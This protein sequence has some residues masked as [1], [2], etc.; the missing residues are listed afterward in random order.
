MPRTRDFRRAF[1][2]VSTGYRKSGRVSPC[3]IQRAPRS[4]ARTS[5]CCWSTTTMQ[6]SCVVE[7]AFALDRCVPEIH[8][9]KDGLEAMRFLRRQG[10]FADA[11]RPDL[12]LLDLNLRRKNGREVLVEIKRDPR[13]RGIPVVVL[14]ASNCEAD[15][16]DTYDLQANCYVTKPVDTEQ[17]TRVA[18]R[19][20]NS[21]APSRSYHRR[22][23]TRGNSRRSARRLDFARVL[24][25]P[26]PAPSSSK[27]CRSA[28]KLPLYS[29]VFEPRHSFTQNGGCRGISATFARYNLKM[30][31]FI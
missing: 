17:F 19:S 6:I 2:R 20:S 15:V 9:V 16:A 7:R 13:L 25:Q 14:T 31:M 23:P 4:R 3:T 1:D 29:T 27:C 28:T 18:E 5:T 21:G 8:V 10:E 24:R 30:R 26:A 22:S 11:P 12:I